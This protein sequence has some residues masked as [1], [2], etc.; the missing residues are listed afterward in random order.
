[1]ETIISGT[2]TCLTWAP[3]EFQQPA[4]IGDISMAL[5]VL[6]FYDSST[7][8]NASFRLDERLSN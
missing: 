4:Q 5:F 3:V 1:M 2:S 6:R 7:M 8:S